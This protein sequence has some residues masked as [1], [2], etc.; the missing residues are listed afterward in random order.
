MRAS[1]EVWVSRTH[2]F[3][4]PRL[5]VLVNLVFLLITFF[6]FQSAWGVKI[7][8]SKID[9]WYRMEQD[10]GVLKTW[11][12]KFQHLFF[13][14]LMQE[15]NRR[16]LNSDRLF[17]TLNVMCAMKEL[18]DKEGVSFRDILC[19][20]I[21]LWGAKYRTERLVILPTFEEDR[22]IWQVRAFIK[23]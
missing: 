3:K 21:G 9:R 22:Q 13:P 5:A 19:N 8:D 16:L 17:W 20:T 10:W 12:D 7:V 2:K 15:S 1:E 4:K 23:F 14:Y 11:P 18:D 6:S